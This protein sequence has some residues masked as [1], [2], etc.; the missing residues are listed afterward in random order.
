MMIVCQKSIHALRMNWRVNMLNLLSQ[1][2]IFQVSTKRF[3]TEQ[4]VTG[5]QDMN[6]LDLSQ[7]M[8]HNTNNIAEVRIRTIKDL[9]LNLQL[10]TDVRIDY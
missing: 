2:E 3:V 7:T 9:L 6:W 10:H 5:N 1:L 4:V 8:G